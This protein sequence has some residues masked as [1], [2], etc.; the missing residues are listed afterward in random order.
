MWWHVLGFMCEGHFSFRTSQVEMDPR[1]DSLDDFSLWFCMVWVEPNQLEHGSWGCIFLLKDSCYIILWLACIVFHWIEIYALTRYNSL[2]YAIWSLVL[3]WC[4]FLLSCGL[5]TLYLQH[6]R[7]SQI[8]GTEWRG[9]LSWLDLGLELRLV[10]VWLAPFSLC[11][12]YCR[13][14]TLIR[15][16]FHLSS[17]PGWSC[18][19]D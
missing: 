1:Y 19:W 3:L 2:V 6:F 7:F 10:V 11:F 18:Y 4:Y 9:V 14:C 15:W 8:G 12:R 13:Y 5:L 16:F 17:D